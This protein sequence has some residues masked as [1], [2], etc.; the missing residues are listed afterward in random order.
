MFALTKYPR[1]V[2][3]SNSRWSAS[4]RLQNPNQQCEPKC[5]ITIPWNYVER[6]RDLLSDSFRPTSSSL[7]CRCAARFRE[8]ENLHSAAAHRTFKT[9][10]S[11][12]SHTVNGACTCSSLS[13]GFRLIILPSARA[14]PVSKAPNGMQRIGHV[15]G[16]RSPE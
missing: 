15:S 1:R 8:K 9:E 2:P 5:F 11:S 14:R 4:R 12:A 16:F 3:H 13:T 7:S 10:Q 6:Q